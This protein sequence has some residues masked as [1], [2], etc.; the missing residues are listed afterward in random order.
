MIQLNNLSKIYRTKEVET[1]A[2]SSINLRVKPGEFVAV[3]GPSGCGKSTLLNIIGMLDRPDSGDY[4]F[5]GKNLQS[6]SESELTKCRKENLGFIFQSFNLVDELTVFENIELPLLYLGYSSTERTRM[7]ET[8]LERMNMMH[9]RNHLPQQLS[10]G[11]QQR[12]AIARAVVHKP[13]LILADEP[14]GNL[15]TSNGIEIMRLLT[16][17]NDLGTT[18]VMVTHSERDADYSSRIIHLLDGKILH[19]NYLNWD[20]SVI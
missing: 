1:V 7:V 4:I 12:A 9:R 16:E 10:G 2:V 17:L 13:K 20:K 5:Q 18:I 11:Q 6:V 19:E 8:V 14:T 3:M 15:D